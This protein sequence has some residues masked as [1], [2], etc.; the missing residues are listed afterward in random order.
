MLLHVYE[1]EREFG[2]S[3]RSGMSQNCLPMQGINIIRGNVSRILFSIPELLRC[4]FY[5]LHHPIY[6][7]RIR[8]SLE[9]Y[10]YIKKIGHISN[11]T[12]FCMCPYFQ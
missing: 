1:R 7:M 8:V 9:I 3:V 12:L 2:H 5:A 11:N 4:Y 10:V 6:R